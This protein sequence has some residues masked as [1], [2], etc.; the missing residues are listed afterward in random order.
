M[1]E[2]NA[3]LNRLISVLLKRIV[4]VNFEKIFYFNSLI[5]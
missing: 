5:K 1:R 2:E 4:F 3:L